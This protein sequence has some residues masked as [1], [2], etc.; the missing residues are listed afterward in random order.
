MKSAHTLGARAP[1]NAAVLRFCRARPTPHPAEAADRREDPMPDRTPEAPCPPHRWEVTSRRRDGA[2]VEH[3]RCLRCGAEKDIPFAVAAG[4]TRQITLG[5]RLVA[6][7][8][9][10][11][12]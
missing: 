4:R 8:P 5:P 11:R 1:E 3:H 10:A 6:R 2:S 7:H 12:S 9:P